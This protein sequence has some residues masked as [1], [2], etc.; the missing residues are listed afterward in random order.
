MG[1]ESIAIVASILLAFGIDAWW[2]ARSE[3]NRTNDLLRNL[4]VE[5][6]AE[7]A[8]INSTLDEFAGYRNIMAEVFSL[9]QQDPGLLSEKMALQFYENYRWDTYKPSTAA[10]DIVLENGLNRVDDSA[11]ALAI[12]SWSSAL[13]ELAPEQNALMDVA[14]R[15]LREAQQN[16]AHRLNLPV[17]STLDSSP[18]SWYGPEAGRFVQA[19]FMDEEVLRVHRLLLDLAG[20]YEMQL[21]GTQQ[22]LGQNISRLQGYLRN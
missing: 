4:E 13:E 17:V 15:R 11:L 22:M 8:R 9:H 1:A 3:T 14:L 16:V 20:D 6:V 10:L 5:W 12:S 18:F 21:R 7:S 2:D 19:I